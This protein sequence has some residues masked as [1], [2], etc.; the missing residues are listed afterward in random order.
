MNPDTKTVVVFP[1]WDSGCFPSTHSVQSYTEPHT[2]CGHH[3]GEVGSCLAGSLSN[4]TTWALRAQRCCQAS[5]PTFDLAPGISTGTLCP[6]LSRADL[7]NWLPKLWDTQARLR[8]K[9]GG[10][11]S[12]AL[13]IHLLNLQPNMEL[14]WES[15][16][17][18]PHPASLAHW[19]CFSLLD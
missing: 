7:L 12:S 19:L 13:T 9:Q 8:E 3:R 18:A 2:Q 14:G 10:D 1:S 17:F 11:K 15:P 6:V 16:G 5:A 4:T